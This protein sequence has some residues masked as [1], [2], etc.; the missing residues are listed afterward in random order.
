MINKG[1]RVG[2]MAK[3]HGKTYKVVSIA[4]NEHT[5][6]LKDLAN[7][8]TVRA[9][10]FEVI[11]DAS[12]SRNA[13]V[14]AALAWKEKTA[15]NAKFKVGDYVLY[16]GHGEGYRRG[17]I[18][19]LGGTIGS[20]GC[21]VEWVGGG[22]DSV[23]YTRLTPCNSAASDSAVAANATPDIL[24]YVKKAPY[25]ASVSRDGHTVMYTSKTMP[26]SKAEG[27]YREVE[28]YL[29]K[30]VKVGL[31]RFVTIPLA[32][33]VPYGKTN[34][35]EKSFILSVSI[36]DLA[37]ANAAVATNAG[38]REGN[39]Q[40]TIETVDFS[41]NRTQSK[42]L[43]ASQLKTWLSLIHCDGSDSFLDEIASSSRR[44]VQF[45]LDMHPT[46][47]IKAM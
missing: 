24:G 39:Y 11:A 17:R 40:V 21:V 28:K 30:R 9:H 41:G 29:A 2:G 34:G 6:I 27:V 36:P 42:N 13:I 16:E 7:G 44:E 35:G 26:E 22:R 15:A 19:S 45:F 10:A 5:V 25:A 1:V 47:K 43:T 14:N 3:Y 12:A 32:P 4:D 23:P 18:V 38:V 8:E 31:C 33:V 46:I 37:V 20:A